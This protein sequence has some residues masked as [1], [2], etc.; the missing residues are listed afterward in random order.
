MSLLNSATYSL[1]AERRAM[2]SAAVTPTFSFSA[3]TVTSG[4]WTARKS[5]ESSLEPLSTTTV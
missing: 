4:Q 3:S 5:S 1:A 2:F